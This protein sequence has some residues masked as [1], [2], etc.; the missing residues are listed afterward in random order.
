MT[1]DIKF[2]NRLGFDFF[3]PKPASSNIPSW[4][5]NTESYISGKKEIIDASISQTIKKCIPVFDSLTAGYIFYTQVDVYIKQTEEGPYYS[6]ASQDFVSFHP[7]S[8]AEL[9][10]VK[11]ENAIPKFTNHYGI[12]TPKGYSVLIVPP[13]HN[14]NNIFTILPAIVDTDQYVNPVEFIFTLDDP[15]FEGLIPAGTPMAQVIPFKRDVWKMKIGKEE[16]IQKIAKNYAKLKTRW[17][18]SYKVQFWTRKEF[19]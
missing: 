10:P 12:E 1:K 7:K 18:D 3:P 5:K 11:T 8:Q 6:W 17:F 2:T 4:Y 16:E 9:Y 19:K 15:N 14:P 13:M